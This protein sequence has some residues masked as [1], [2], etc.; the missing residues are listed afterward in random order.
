MGLTA[1]TRSPGPT[2]RWPRDEAV[3]NPLAAGLRA[4]PRSAVSYWNEL[5]ERTRAL[6]IRT[7][8][9]PT[10]VQATHCRPRG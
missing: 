5:F 7:E 9:I 1:I 6:Y 4:V 2:S 8:D 3:D 10:V